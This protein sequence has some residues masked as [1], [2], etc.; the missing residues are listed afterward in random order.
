MV[1]EV[2]DELGVGREL[3]VVAG[4][5]VGVDEEGAGA[6]G[7]GVE[8][9]EAALVEDEVLGVV[10]PEEGGHVVAG[11]VVAILFADGGG[12]EGVELGGGG[13]DAGLAGAGVDL[14]DV[15]GVAD[16]VVLGHEGEAGAVGAPAAAAGWVAG[17]VA[18]GEGD[19]A[20]AGALSGSVLGEG[21]GGGE[22]QE[23]GQAGSVRHMVV[24]VYRHAAGRARGGP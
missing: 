20:G 10:G 13:E 4:A 8:P 5:L 23:Q 2:G 24:R 1:A 14:D 7:D 3:G 21:G 6:V 9:E 17:G 16:L 18:V 11:A 19:G 12:G 22:G 15:A